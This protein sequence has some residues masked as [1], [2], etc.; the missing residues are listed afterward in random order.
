MRRATRVARMREKINASRFSSEG[1]ERMRPLGRARY[2][3]KDNIKM[4]QI[5]R[6]GNLRL[7]SSD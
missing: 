5:N 2:K 7:I 6:M 4:D 3:L 1:L